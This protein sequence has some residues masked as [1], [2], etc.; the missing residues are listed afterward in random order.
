MY[1]PLRKGR[2]NI[3]N[4]ERFTPEEAAYYTALSMYYEYGPEEFLKRADQQMAEICSAEVPEEMRG[5]RDHSRCRAGV[6]TFW[7]AWNG[8]M[9]PCGMM[10][11]PALDVRKEGFAGAWEQI[12]ASMRELLLPAKCTACGKKNSCATCAAMVLAETGGYEEAPRY[13]CR[14]MEAYGDGCRKVEAQIKNHELRED[15]WNE[16]LGER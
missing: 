8:R 14:M 12:K 6:S 15:I 2:D 13:R 3:G 10:D 1:P 11:L 16:A 5:T 9:T 7:L 4:N